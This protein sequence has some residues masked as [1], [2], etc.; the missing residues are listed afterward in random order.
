MEILNNWEEVIDFAEGLIVFIFRGLQ[1]RCKYHMGV[2]QREYPDAGN[3]KIP[4]GK[5]PRIR[6]A[7]GIAMLREAGIDASADEDISTPHEK[8]LG[9]LVLEKYKTDFYFLTHYPIAARPFYTHLDPKNQRLTHSY[10]A[11]MRGQEIV[12]GA[13]RVHDPTMLVERMKS[14]D[15]P[16]TP[17]SE[18][19]RHYV[20]AFRMGCAPHGGGGFGL[21]R[22]TMLWLGLGNI[23]Q[24]TLF[25]RD[26]QRKAP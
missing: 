13:Q 10:D 1:E 19:F 26:P 3:F 23:R 20:D 8:A 15:P 7:D 2:I 24:T 5:A 22:I 14:M 18:G 9:A 4:D 17:D 6:F 21:N 16:L 25:P 11:F 12:S